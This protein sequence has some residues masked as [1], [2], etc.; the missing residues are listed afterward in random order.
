MPPLRP[1]DLAMAHI[2]HALD[3][4]TFKQPWNPPQGLQPPHPNVPLV[5]AQAGNNSQ[6]EGLQ[7]LCLI[8]ES[9]QYILG[10]N[11]EQLPPK[12]LDV[13]VPYGCGDHATDNAAVNTILTFDI[14]DI[15]E[16][17]FLLRVFATAGLE[18]GKGKLG[19]KTCDDKKKALYRRLETPDDVK[20]AF[21]AHRKMLES[22]RHK[23]PVYMEVANLVSVS[24]E[25]FFRWL[26]YL[27]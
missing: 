15:E 1:E 5:A 22:K 9:S 6:R 25:L 21:N 8:S 2:Q 13:H 10:A 14:D 19:W 11:L 18:R 17:D 4:G 23:R 16:E 24:S 20:H 12:R 3:G 27:L 26:I 7:I